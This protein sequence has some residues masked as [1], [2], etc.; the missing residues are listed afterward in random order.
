MLTRRLF[1]HLFNQQ[2]WRLYRLV[3]VEVTAAI[4]AST[5]AYADVHLGPE[6]IGSNYSV[7]V[8]SWWDIPFRTIVRQRYDFSC[9]SAAVATLLTHQYGLKTAEN[10]PF[11]AMWNAGDRKTIRKAGFSMLDMKTYLISRGFKTEGF[12]MPIGDFRKLTQPSIVLLNLN[13]YRHF[14]VVKGVRGDTVLVGDPMR[15]LTKYRIEDFAKVWNGIVLTITY[16]PDRQQGRYNLAYDWDP[17]SKSPLSSFARNASINDL[18]AYLAP[19]Y[20]ITPNSAL[21]VQIP[22]AP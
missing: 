18:T 1:L 19:Q 3:L 10:E 5:P 6:A 17:W 8:V 4:L 21:G 9:G 13:G 11:M 2:A 16:A 12:R 15:G 22:I 14:V 20:Q 7:R